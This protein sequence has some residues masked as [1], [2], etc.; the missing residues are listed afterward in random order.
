MAKKALQADTV[1]SVEKAP[2]KAK[3]PKATKAVEAPAE[4]TVV[5]EAPKAKKSTKAN[6]EA[7]APAPAPEAETASKPTRAR[8]AKKDFKDMDEAEKIG[9]HVQRNTYS[10]QKATKEAKNELYAQEKIFVEPGDELIA[11]T[12]SKQRKT[13]WIE[14]VAS[15]NEGRILKGTIVSVT[16]VPSNK[17]DE[18]DYV[19]EFMAKVKF[20]TGQFEVEIPSYVLYDYDQTNINR[21]TAL[22]IQRN[23]MHRLGAEIDF[24]VRYADEKTGKVL[25]DRLSSLSMRGVQNYTS[26]NGRAPRI[27]PGLIVQSKIISVQRDS[28]TVDAAGA[29]FTIPIEE[30]SWLYMQDARDFDGIKTNECYQ[31]GGRVNVKI[32]AVSTKKVR[33]RNSSY[34]L[35]KATG[36]IKQAKPNPRERYFHEFNV[37]DIYAGIVTGITESGVYVN[38]NDKCDCLCKFPRDGHRIPILGESMIVKI[39]A[40]DEEKK[41]IYGTFK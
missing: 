19:P 20:M 13:E 2:K 10:V 7:E 14:L 36:S 27:L 11:E 26:I 34:T 16:E 18:P 25:G 39:N 28:I 5:E 17:V 31:V 32:L 1:E 9:V 24:V 4:E 15:A 21:T 23:M 8:R 40:K 29:E 30:I 22:G 6:V 33:V 38:L 3:T 37:G 41:F 35:I 12:E